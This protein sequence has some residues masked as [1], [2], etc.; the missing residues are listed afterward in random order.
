MRT[1][2]I[3]VISTLFMLLVNGLAN[4]GVFG[5]ET[6]ASVAVKLANLFVPAGFTFSIWGVIYLLQGIGLYQLFA[7]KKKASGLLA[8]LIGVNL[9]NALWIVLWLNLLVGFAWV[10]LLAL[11]VTLVYAV[12]HVRDSST[13]G[14]PWLNA[15][16]QI[17]AGWCAVASIA[18]GAAFLVTVFGDLSPF[19]EQVAYVSVSCVGLMMGVL[20]ANLAK[21]IFPLLPI[22]WAFIG[23]ANAHDGGGFQQAADYTLVGL[24]ALLVVFKWNQFRLQ[25]SS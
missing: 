4:T 24:A 2:V 15:F 7:R 16:L 3:A 13:L 17:Y 21:T 12:L 11:T 18:N 10:V 9:L 19:V 1:Y 25:N 6:M 20:L 23:L 5:G 14:G 8:I 22:L